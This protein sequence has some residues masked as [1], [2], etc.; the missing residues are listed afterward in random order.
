MKYRLLTQYLQNLS[1]YLN[2]VISNSSKKNETQS[3]FIKDGNITT[4]PVFEKLQ[5]LRVAMEKLKPLDEK[6]EDQIVVALTNLKE[7]EDVETNDEASSEEDD[8][9]AIN[10]LQELAALRSEKMKKQSHHKVKKQ[11]EKQKFLEE[12][13]DPNLDLGEFDGDLMSD[14]E[15]DQENNLDLDLDSMMNNTIVPNL[16]IQKQTGKIN[17]ITGKKTKKRSVN[18]Q[19]SVPLDLDE[20]DP[21]LGARRVTRGVL[22]HSLNAVDM[23]ANK[24]INKHDKSGDVN[25][26]YRDRKVKRLRL[27]DVEKQ[28]EE[29]GHFGGGVKNENEAEVN[30]DDTKKQNENDTEEMQFKLSKQEKRAAK[31]AANAAARLPKSEKVIEGARKIN[32]AIDKNRGLVR[33]RKK[34]DSNSR[35]KK[36]QKFEKMQ[37]NLKGKVVQMQEGRQDGGY[38]GEMSGMRTHVKKSVAIKS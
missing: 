18:D 14:E 37:K 7:D 26:D 25:V 27:E 38:D 16:K 21:S 20:A 11:L 9:E 24:N 5:D 6:F 28:A 2:L 30:N 36:R 8:D 12:L 32:K 31:R 4:H 15:E 29:M 35:V 10:T 34:I 1:F 33:V 22:S 19:S 13:N 3:K 23:H 17:E